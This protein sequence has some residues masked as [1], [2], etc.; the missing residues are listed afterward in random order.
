MLNGTG[1]LRAEC[2]TCKAYSQNEVNEVTMIAMLQEHAQ[3]SGV[4]NASYSYREDKLGKIG[5]YRGQ[6]EALGNTFIN[7]SIAGK[8][9]SL[10]LSGSAP[11][12]FYSKLEFDRFLKFIEKIDKF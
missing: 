6:I 8:R 12:K 2:I 9:S 10:S 1:G 4:T 5:I 3:I 11:Y 7:V